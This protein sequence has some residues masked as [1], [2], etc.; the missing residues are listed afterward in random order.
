MEHA[1]LCLSLRSFPFWDPGWICSRMQLRGPGSLKPVVAEGP[2]PSSLP[3][4]PKLA[5][6]LCLAGP[7]PPWED[8]IFTASVLQ[9]A[10][11]VEDEGTRQRG[12][13]LK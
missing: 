1:H 3:L 4:L 11:C 10:A 9:L 7:R 8:C 5:E 13:V 6:C 2:R 12:R